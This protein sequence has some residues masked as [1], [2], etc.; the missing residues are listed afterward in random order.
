MASL[1]VTPGLLRRQGGIRESM[2]SNMKALSILALGTMLLAGVASNAHAAPTTYRIDKAH[3]AGHFLVKHL[4]VAKVRGKIAPIQG[5]V[6]IDDKNVENSSVK[7]DVP[8]A[9]IDTGVEKRDKHLRSADFFDAKNHPKLSFESTRVIKKP[10]GKHEIVG[11]LTMRGNTKI[12]IFK[13]D[14]LTPESKNPFGP[15]IRALTATTTVNRHDFGL[16]WNKVVEG[17]QVVSD[18]VQI[19][20][21]LELIRNDNSKN[22]S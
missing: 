3:S 19:T 10:D 4:G 13:L 1:H 8:I 17:V 16:S 12:V 21:E 7:G 11:K 9:N 6:T 14:E 5:V 2:E 18:D 20:I 15:P 22:K